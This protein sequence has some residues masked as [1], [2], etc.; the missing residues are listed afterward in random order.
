MFKIEGGPYLSSVTPISVH[1]QMRTNISGIEGI[2]IKPQVQETGNLQLSV[3]TLRVRTGE[4]AREGGRERG[5]EREKK[6]GKRQR[7]RETER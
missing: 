4:R 2:L 6:R 1:R 7:D 5:R 3:A